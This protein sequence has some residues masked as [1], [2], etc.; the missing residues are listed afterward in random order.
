[1]IKFNNTS[2]RRSTN[3]IFILFLFDFPGVSLSIF[4]INDIRI[5]NN[6]KIIYF[7][8]LQLYIGINRNVK[9]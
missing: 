4:L 7:G 9:P 5:D 6:R 3:L 2:E 8:G 1:M